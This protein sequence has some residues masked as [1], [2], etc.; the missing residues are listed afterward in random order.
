MNQK[1]CPRENR[2]ICVSALSG[3]FSGAARLKLSGPIGADGFGLGLA[4][5]RRA[6]GLHQGS[7]SAKAS[8]AGGLS[9]A[10]LLPRLG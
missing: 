5:A 6:I 8:E 7:I 2:K 1:V 10:I 9:V 3:F 4:I